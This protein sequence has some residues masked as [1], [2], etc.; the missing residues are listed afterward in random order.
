MWG[1]D[2]PKLAACRPGVRPHR[3]VCDIK[4]TAS[5]KVAASITANPATGSEQ[6]PKGPAFVSILFASVFRTCT[7]PQH[8]SGRRL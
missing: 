7:G 6:D 2:R 4:S 8:P 1:G 3:G 5:A